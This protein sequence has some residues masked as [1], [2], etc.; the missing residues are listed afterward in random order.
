MN[1]NQALIILFR[2][3]F[4]ANL[5]DPNKQFFRVKSTFKYCDHLSDSYA[6]DKFIT[7]FGVKVTLSCFTQSSNINEVIRSVLNF[8]FF[9]W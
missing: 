3:G 7:I 1:E 5:T 6:M 4:F 9:L 2:W 8:L